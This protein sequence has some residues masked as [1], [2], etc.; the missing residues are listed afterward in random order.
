M[1]DIQNTAAGRG[2]VRAVF[3]ERCR[4]FAA[5]LDLVR[6]HLRVVGRLAWRGRVQKEFAGY[7]VTDSDDAALRRLEIYGRKYAE[8]AVDSEAG[9][10]FSNARE[11]YRPAFDRLA[12]TGRGPWSFDLQPGFELGIIGCIDAPGYLPAGAMRAYRCEQ[13][14][15]RIRAPMIRGRE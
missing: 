13:S 12:T 3:L 14:G 8:K 5:P 1:S 10:P 9:Y 2:H 7:L 15:D 6:V 4:G 11:K